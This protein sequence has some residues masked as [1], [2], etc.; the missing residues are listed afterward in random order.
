MPFKI[1]RSVEATEMLGNE[2]F[3]R[4][5]LSLYRACPWATVAQSPAFVTSWYDHYKEYSPILVCEFSD[6]RTMTGFLPIAVHL[7]GQAVLAGAHQ[8]EYKSWLALPSNGNSFL[9]AS[10][11]LL[12]RKTAIGALSFRYLPSGAPVGGAAGLSRLPW[13]CEFEAHSRPM[14]RLTDAA[15]VAEYVRQ[16]TNSTIRNSWKRLNRVGKVHLEQIRESEELVPIF[17]QLIEWYDTRQAMAHGKKPFEADGNKKAWHLRLLKEGVLHLTLLRAGQEVL[18]AIFG[19]SDGKTYSMMMPMFA[20]EY[21]RYSPIAIHHLLLVEQ[22]HA[23]GYSVLDL[24]PGPD[25]F[26]ERFAGAYETVNV[27][28]VYFKQRAWFKAKVRQQSHAFTKGMLSALGIE[29]STI[30]RTI[31]RIQALLRLKR[32]SR[33][34]PKLSHT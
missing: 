32:P 33:P 34:T 7:S 30:A 9:E 28:S 21:G 29:P 8:A 16:K 31:P 27:L 11:R 2:G 14:V 5:W 1:A 25:P 4:Q 23:D 13:I 10:L 17:D 22:L 24:T 18:S 12:S 19:L 26:K 15:E 20:P 6:S 3:R